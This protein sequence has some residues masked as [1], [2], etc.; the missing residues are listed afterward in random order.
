M[1]QEQRQALK[2]ELSDSQILRTYGKQFTQI[3]EQF[4]DGLTGRC[5]IGVIMSYHGWDGRDGIDAA[6]GLFAA[7]SE[8]KFAGIDEGILMDL[9]DS[10]MSFDE[11]AD[12]LDRNTIRRFRKCS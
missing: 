8:L 7:L 3:R 5:A 4:S 9:N 11:I 6:I 2:Q 12:Y 10:G 1:N